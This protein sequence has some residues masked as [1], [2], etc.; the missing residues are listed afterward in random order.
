MAKDTVKASEAKA[1]ASRKVP[2]I[3]AKAVTWNNEGF[4]WREALVR[5]PEG[6]TLQDLNDHPEV[7]RQVQES[8]LASF[9]R[10][11]KVRAVAWDESWIAEAVVNHAD[12]GQV[13]LAGIR[14]IDFPRREI[15]LFEDNTYKVEWLGS[16]YGITRKSDG[17]MMGNQTWP[18]PEGAKA[19]LLSLYHSR[20][21]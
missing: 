4:A 9:R 2:E 18:T 17:V 5:L 13:I 8:N 14:K 7:W 15:A 12:R 21:A 6:M 11:D 10:F 3:K 20:V 16:G 19:G 1:A